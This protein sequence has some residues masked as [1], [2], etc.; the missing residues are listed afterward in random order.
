M[1]R[2]YSW[3]GVF[4]RFEDG[5]APEGAVLVEAASAV[6]PETRTVGAEQEGQPKAAPKRRTTRRAK[7]KADPQQ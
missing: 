1:L 4:W 6:T 2:T 7:P 3:R 5:A